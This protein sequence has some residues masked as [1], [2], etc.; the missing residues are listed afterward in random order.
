MEGSKEGYSSGANRVEGE[1]GVPRRKR[2]HYTFEERCR[3]VEAYLGSGLTLAA[4]ERSYGVSQVTLRRWM[5]RHA[6]GGGR[7][8]RTS[9]TGRAD[10]GAS[11]R[12]RRR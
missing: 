1:A 3:A 6:A 8:W 5:R 7:R 11:R 10:R 9:R 4:F 12:S 2:D